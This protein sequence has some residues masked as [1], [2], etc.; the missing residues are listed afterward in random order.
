MK[1]ITFF[2]L[3][4]SAVLKGWSQGCNPSSATGTP[5]C[6]ALPTNFPPIN[7]LGSA[8]WTNTWNGNALQGGLYPNGSNSI[9]AAHQAAGISL[10]SQ[11]QPL[12]TAGNPSAN[13]KIVLLS[14]GLSNTNI[15]SCEFDSLA[16]L[17][18]CKNSKVVCVNG[19]Q[20]G[21]A[22]ACIAINPPPSPCGSTA[23]N[24]YW[25]SKSNPVGVY[26]ALVTAGGSRPKQ[27]QA[28]WF[29]ETNPATLYSTQQQFYDSLTAQLKRILKEMVT[30]YPNIKVCYISSRISAR[31]ADPAS[32]LNPEPYAYIQG[33]AVK[34]VIEDQISGNLPYAG[35]NRVA[36]WI[37]WSPYL[38]SDGNIPRQDGFSWTCP[39]DFAKD[40]THPSLSGARTVGNLLLC[41]FKNDP[42]TYPWFT[43][44]GNPCSGSCSLTAIQEMSENETIKIYPN[45]STGQ[46]TIHCLTATAKNLDIY[47][48]FGKLVFHTIINSKQ[49]TINLNIA[50]GIYFLKLSDGTDSYRKKLII[51]D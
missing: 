18:A 6:G 37:S 45:P 12:D 10:A 9:P 23:Y 32:Q 49:E 11:I 25:G 38:W 15:E 4:F 30:R 51:T 22:A 50:K 13:G 19:A 29:K 24:N 1:K 48:M 40:G 42:T 27:V 21:A 35:P 14:I 33:W 20:G 46:F 41:F 16:N 43:S 5:N 34:K 31:Y 8:T 17:D 28:V 3:L 2:L 47:D 39:N 7:D 36:P 44:N 26:G